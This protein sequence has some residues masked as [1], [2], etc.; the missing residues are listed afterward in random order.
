MVMTKSRQS[1]YCVIVDNGLGKKIKNLSRVKERNI[2]AIS[3]GSMLLAT[4]QG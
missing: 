1:T 4:Y 2:D 3:I